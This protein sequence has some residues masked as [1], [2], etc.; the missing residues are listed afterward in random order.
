MS[1]K[2]DFKLVLALLIVGLV[3][4]T[5]YLG[6]RIAVETMQPWFVTSIRQ[7]I[8]GLIVFIILVFKKEIAWIGWKNFRI[9]L[10][11]AILMLVFANGF[12]TVAE[13]SIPSGLTSI[14]SALSPVIIFIGSVL[15]GIQKANWK[16]F[17]GVL[18]GFTGVVF[19]FRNG[20]SDLLDPDYKN[21]ILFLS[22]AIVSWST[23]VLL[24]KKHSHDSN[25]ITLNLFYQFTSAAI[26]Q[27][28]LAFIVYPDAKIS[29][30]S[31]R[32]IL[33]TSY[34]AVFGSVVAFFCY[35]YA[36]KRVSAVRVSI[37]NYVNTIIAIFLGWLVLDE[38]I[39]SDF[40]IASALIMTGVFIINFK[41]K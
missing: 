1:S 27:L 34:L 33:A 3:W 7:G 25:N 22:F 29:E 41:R 8:A 31:M 24:S 11:L 38:V 10:L 5:T 4:G 36:L 9:Q 2:L 12:T 39:T 28:I 30:W 37:L 35:Y 18:L 20:L 15:F 17:F 13:H 23:G 21:G 19:I 6:I 32:S 40:I 14:M 16:G 26:I